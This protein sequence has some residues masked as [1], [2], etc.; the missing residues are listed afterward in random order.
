MELEARHEQPMPP[1]WSPGNALAIEPG[2]A[3]TPGDSVIQPSA[4]L[5]ETLLSLV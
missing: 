2:G 1:E 5:R 3:L 4:S